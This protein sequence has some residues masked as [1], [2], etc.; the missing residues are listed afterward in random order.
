METLNILK[1]Y[2]VKTVELGIQSMVENVL[3]S[4][5]RFYS[6]NVVI[7]SMNEIV[8]NSFNLGVQIMCGLFN[9]QL[10][11]FIY[12]VNTLKSLNFN[13]VRIYPTIVIKNTQLEKI[14]NENK[15]TPLSVGEAICYCAYGFIKFVSSGKT[16][17]RMGLHNSDILEHSI[18]AGP[19]HR[20]F[21]DLVKIYILYLYLLKS[22]SIIIGD[23][24]K[25]LIS[26]YSGLIK[27]L[28]G[29]KIIIHSNN[30]IDWIT[31]CRAL[32]NEDI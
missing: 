27:K 23:N 1:R 2:N 20:S 31:I 10:D 3:V 11:D 24:D 28:F 16:V 7:N 4:N 30:R 12:T 13:F 18:V 6:E 29:H 5:N 15:F 21:G 19:Y 14:F 25:S 17:I 9:E 26:G 8:D 32:E 22:D